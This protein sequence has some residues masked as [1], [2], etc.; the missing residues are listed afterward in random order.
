MFMG[1]PPGYDSP[2]FE[3]HLV[4]SVKTGKKVRDLLFSWLGVC[5]MARMAEFNG[6]LRA[7]E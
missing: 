5:L 4:I 1:F 3:I 7:R 2:E 6:R